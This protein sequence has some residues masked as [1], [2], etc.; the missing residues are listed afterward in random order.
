MLHKLAGFPLPSNL[1]RR[2]RKSTPYKAIMLVKVP[3]DFTKKESDSE[4][5][6]S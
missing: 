4:N 2:K 3:V 6:T 1:N 5:I